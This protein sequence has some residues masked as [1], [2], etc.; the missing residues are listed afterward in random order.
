L[1]DRIVVR[2]VPYG[3][4]TSDLVKSIAQLAKEG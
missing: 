2:A 3:T 4:N 1:H